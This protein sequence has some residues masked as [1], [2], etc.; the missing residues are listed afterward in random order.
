MSAQ[1]SNNS[2]MR[3]SQSYNISYSPVPK[4]PAE[5]VPRATV[6][7]PLPLHL[8]TPEEAA[9]GAYRARLSPGCLRRCR[10]CPCAH[11]ASENLPGVSED[12]LVAA[13]KAS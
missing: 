8:S 7:P 2:A 10:K 13:I 3:Q 1:L 6:G 11:T 12:T 9:H 5:G 4:T